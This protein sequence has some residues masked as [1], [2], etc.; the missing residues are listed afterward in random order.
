MTENQASFGDYG[1]PNGIDATRVVH[2]NDDHDTYGGRGTRGA[3]MSNTPPTMSGW[4]G[5]PYRLANQGREAAVR[6]FQKDFYDKLWDDKKF[7]NAV[8]AL[9]GDD[10]ACWCRHRGEDEPLCH[11]DVVVEAIER[12]HTRAILIHKHDLGAATTDGGRPP[13]YH[14]DEVYHPIS[15]PTEDDDE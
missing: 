3:D 7:C 5:N 10:I 12:G 15:G 6:E 14:G 1:A 11:L 4:L 8:D 9:K 2:K 13:W